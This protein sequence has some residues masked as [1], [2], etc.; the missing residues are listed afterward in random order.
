MQ[1]LLFYCFWFDRFA[2]SR[3]AMRS[4]ACDIRFIPWKANTHLLIYIWFVWR[5]S[6]CFLPFSFIIFTLGSSLSPKTLHCRLIF[7]L[8]HISIALRHL[9]SH[10]PHLKICIL[11]NE[12]LNWHKEINFH[13]GSETMRNRCF[14]F[15]VLRL[16]YF[17]P[18]LLK[19]IVFF[20][21][22]LN[23]MQI[24]QTTQ[25]KNSATVE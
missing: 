15:F 23:R 2:L 9:K 18:I 14:V 21:A 25:Q 7:A 19:N 17:S 10:R 13:A 6:I 16:V 12:K 4:N 5:N 24:I 1:L 20:F 11:C 3:N 8:R 22:T